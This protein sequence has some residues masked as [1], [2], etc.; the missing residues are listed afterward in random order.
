M[1]SVER[2]GLTPGLRKLSMG[3]RLRGN[4]GLKFNNYGWLT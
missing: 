2:C 3:S 4:D 1:L